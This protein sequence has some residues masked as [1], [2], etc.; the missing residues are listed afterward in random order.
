[1][2]SHVSLRRAEMMD[3]SE[4]QQ[5]LEIDFSTQER[6]SYL[7]SFQTAASFSLSQ[8]GWLQ[9]GAAAWWA[10]SWQRFQFKLSS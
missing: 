9:A 6:M 1:V 7:S 3:A 10:S 5:L 2:L 8:T 4:K